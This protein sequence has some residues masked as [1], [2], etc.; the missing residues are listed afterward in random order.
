MLEAWKSLCKDT[1]VCEKDYYRNNCS[2]VFCREDVLKY[3]R[4]SPRKHASG[5]FLETA[6]Y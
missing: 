3:Y 6:T 1:L 5:S 4:K 2:Q